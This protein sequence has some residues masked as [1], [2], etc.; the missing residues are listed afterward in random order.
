MSNEDWK[1]TWQKLTMEESLWPVAVARQSQLNLDVEQKL[2]P[3]A[4]NPG[5][6]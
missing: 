2:K 3:E 5:S 6:R 1:A 4:L